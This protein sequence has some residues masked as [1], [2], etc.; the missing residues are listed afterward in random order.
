MPR[1]EPD[2]LIE[3]FRTAD[4][5]GLPSVEAMREA[6]EEIPSRRTSGASR[7]RSVASRRSGY[8]RRA[9]QPRRSSCTFTAAVT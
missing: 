8:E 9:R 4:V 2:A 3:Q 6:I 1:P 5:L 7:S